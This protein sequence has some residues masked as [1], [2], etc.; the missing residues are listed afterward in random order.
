MVLKTATGLPDLEIISK[1]IN[2][3]RL[4]LELFGGQQ[5]AEVEQPV[6]VPIC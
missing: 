1:V 3:I 6:D 5:R 4:D 2:L